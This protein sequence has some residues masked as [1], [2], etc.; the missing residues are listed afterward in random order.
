MGGG[1]MRGE[2]V[3][4]GGMRNGVV[5]GEWVRNDGM[6][7]GGVRGGAVRGGAVRGGAVR[8]EMVRIGRL[9]EENKGEEEERKTLEKMQ[10]RKAELGMSILYS[11]RGYCQTYSTVLNYTELY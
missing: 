4:G 6:R 11:Y 9:V 7:N 1:G 5:R 3:R 8:G 10:C 2:E